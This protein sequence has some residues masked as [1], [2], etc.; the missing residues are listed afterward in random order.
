MILEYIGY[1]ISAIL[2][3]TSLMLFISGIYA[4]Y[5]YLTG[6]T[7][8]KKSS[9]QSSRLMLLSALTFLASLFVFLVTEN[10]F[11]WNLVATFL[12]FSILILGIVL[13]SNFVNS[14][15]IMKESDKRSKN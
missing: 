7:T 9:E 12:F 10:G 13:L 8:Q 4:G 6:F 3:L 14:F 2:A 5:K 1:S 15:T 11:S